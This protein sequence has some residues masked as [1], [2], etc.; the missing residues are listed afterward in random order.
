MV[1]ASYLIQTSVI[2]M[3]PQSFLATKKKPAPAEEDKGQMMLH[4]F[5][6][7]GGQGV[8]VF[9]WAGMYRAAGQWRNRRDDAETVT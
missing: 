9:P 2:N 7:R 1:P 4:G 5:P 3:G 6:F 8:E